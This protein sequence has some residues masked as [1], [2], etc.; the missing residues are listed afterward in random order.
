MDDRSVEAMIK[1]KF[2]RIEKEFLR[3]DLQPPLIIWNPAEDRLTLRPLKAL[4][5]YWNSLPRSGGIPLASAVDPMEMKEA[6]GYVMLLDPVERQKEGPE[7]APENREGMAFRYRLYG[8]EIARY[9]GFDMTGKTTLD[10]PTSSLMGEFFGC[11][12]R[13]IMKRPE[14][15]LTVHN[16]P[17][18]ARISSWTRLGL[19][20][21][22]DRGTVMRIICGNVPSPLTFDGGMPG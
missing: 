12:Y 2:R 3:H 19:P 18:S 14:A 20:L 5:T 7:G 16:A 10:I 15:L 21:A 1:G 13:A 9:S 8:T 17:K 22:D 4:H 6:L 11:C